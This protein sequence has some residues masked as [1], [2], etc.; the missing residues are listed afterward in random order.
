MSNYA[1]DFNNKEHRD[2]ITRNLAN[3]GNGVIE[4]A[5]DMIE[6]MEQQLARLARE[7]QELRAMPDDK[8][9]DD[10]ARVAYE[11]FWEG[12]DTL[13]TWEGETEGHKGEWRR[14]VRRVLEAK[15]KKER[16]E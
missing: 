13:G 12:T 2:A 16:A 14:V 15:A 5:C 6:A 3:S 11:A 9:I 8:T 1:P 4:D 10:L 7:N